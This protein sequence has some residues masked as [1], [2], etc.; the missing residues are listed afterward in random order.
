MQA[1][2]DGQVETGL[3]NHYYLLRAMAEDPD[4]PGRN[5]F[6]TVATAGSLVM[7]S[8]AGLLG[9]SGNEDAAREFVEYLL[10]QES[11][12]YFAEETFEY[13]LIEGVPA[14]EM[15][16]PIDSLPTPDIDLSLLATTLDTATDLVAEAGLL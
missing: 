1:V 4:L 7:P 9:S 12:G 10:T 6:F 13:P 2:N 5:H 11:Q 3:V 15:L 8:G 14:N 16:P